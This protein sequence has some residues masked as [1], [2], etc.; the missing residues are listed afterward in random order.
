MT[1][2]LHDDHWV[3]RSITNMM[4]EADGTTRLEFEKAC[5]DGVSEAI[6]HG[7]PIGMSTTVDVR[8]VPRS[9]RLRIER[10]KN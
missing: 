9:W 6:A 7:V 3:F 2:S 1:D 10:R 5:E 8:L 4:Y